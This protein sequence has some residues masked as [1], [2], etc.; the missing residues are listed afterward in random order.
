MDLT[1]FT[2]NGC[3]VCHDIEEAFKK[4]YKAEIESGEA[5]IVNLDENEEAQRF[6]MEHDLPVA[7][8]IVV[9]SEKENLICVL[10][11]QDLL[12]EAETPAAEGEKAAAGRAV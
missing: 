8:I 3:Q 2:G 12:K 4:K 5:D 9:V 11:P 7:P 6:W 1:L 10:E